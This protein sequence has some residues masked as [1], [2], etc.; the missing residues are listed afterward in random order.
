MTLQF[1]LNIVFQGLT[2]AAF[3]ALVTMAIVLIF[4]TSYTTN[5]AQ[6]S[7]ATFSAF[8]VTSLFTKF[9]LIRFP[10][11]SP[12]ILLIISIFIGIIIGFLI[13]L[14]IDVF[15]I[16]N[17]ENYPENNVSIFNRWGITVYDVDGYGQDNKYFKGISEGRIT[18]NSQDEL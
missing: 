17:I 12:V 5:F 6:G 15:I 8:A 2:G 14:F 13:G 7:I 18:I 11:I 4:K 3:L 16:R 10:S 1:F 9:F